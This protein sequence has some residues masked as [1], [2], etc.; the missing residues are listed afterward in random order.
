MKVGDVV[1]RVHWGTGKA[2]RQDEATGIIIEADS[3][4]QRSWHLDF[5]DRVYKVMWSDG[6]VKW[7]TPGR[8][9]LANSFLKTNKL[10]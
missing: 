7:E 3:V 2:E 4:E 9:F 6:Q 5:P 1:V 8:I 10:Y